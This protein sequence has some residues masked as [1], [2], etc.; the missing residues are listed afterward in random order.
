MVIPSQL[1]VTLYTGG[2]TLR[3]T[4]HKVR[5]LVGNTALFLPTNPQLISRP[6]SCTQVTPSRT[7]AYPRVTQ[8][9]H[10]K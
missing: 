5:G 1:L 8:D 6:P 10:Y 9:I 3:I 2:D 7:T 4:S